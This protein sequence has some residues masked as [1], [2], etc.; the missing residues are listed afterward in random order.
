MRDARSNPEAWVA[1]YVLGATPGGSLTPISSPPADLT[2]L[3]TDPAFAALPW[4]V[5]TT[6]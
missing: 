2:T 5:E 1:V 3:L 6:P 4:P